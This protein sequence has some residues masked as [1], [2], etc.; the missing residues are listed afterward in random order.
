MAVESYCCYYYAEEDALLI[1][2]HVDLDDAYYYAVH[3]NDHA[4]CIDIVAVLDGGDN[5]LGEDVVSL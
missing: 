3:D 2:V 5:A 1:V 4:E